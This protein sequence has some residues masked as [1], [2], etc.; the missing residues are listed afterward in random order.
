MENPQRDEIEE[1]DSDHRQPSGGKIIGEKRDDDDQSKTE[2]DEME[3]L[4]PAPQATTLP[5]RRETIIQKL[6]KK[7]P[8]LNKTP[9]IHAGSMGSSIKEEIPPPLPKNYP[10]VEAFN[11]RLEYR[12]QRHRY[13]AEKVEHYL[14]VS[15]GL[16]LLFLTLRSK[17]SRG[18]ST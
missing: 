15:F 12:R 17:R 7:I 1:I 3:E 9:K 18:P 13:S 10:S 11:Q 8:K 6:V 5:L 4:K 14:R 16:P 2:P